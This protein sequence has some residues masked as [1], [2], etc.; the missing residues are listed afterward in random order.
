MTAQV[1]QRS[2]DRKKAWLHIEDC[3]CPWGWTSGGRLYGVSMGNDWH[4]LR[5]ERGCRH[6]D[7]CTKRISGPVDPRRPTW[8]LSP[9]C[10]RLR[11]HEGGCREDYDRE[12]GVRS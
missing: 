1:V 2:L 6:H 10:H 5:T 4:R 3:L 8:R 7:L 9:W 12:H 11:G